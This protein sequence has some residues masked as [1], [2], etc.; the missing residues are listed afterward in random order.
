[1]KIKV[2]EGRRVGLGAQNRPQEAPRR[3]KK[4]TSKKEERKET[5]RRTS[6][7]TKRTSKIFGTAWSQCI[8]IALDVLFVFRL[9]FFLSMSFFISSRNLL[10]SIL[11]SQTDPPTFKNVDSMAA[12]GRLLKNL[13]FRS[14]DGFGSVLGSSRL[15]L[16]RFVGSPG[17]IMGAFGGPWA[18]KLL[19][20]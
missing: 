18:T 8:F 10:G 9:S 19:R 1:M 5:K 6:R 20:D 14:K 11:S 3:D 2:F 7:A 13:R 12:G 17:V 16:G 4:T 15:H